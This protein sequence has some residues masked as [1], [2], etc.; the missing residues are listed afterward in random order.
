MTFAPS[1]YDIPAHLKKPEDK[2]E[3]LKE[4]ILIINEK[5]EKEHGA[6]ISDENV[7]VVNEMQ[8]IIEDPK[9]A[10]FRKIAERIELGLKT[11]NTV[12]L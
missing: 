12:H 4:E 5:Q 8:V 10:W 1:V 2:I 7:E 3:G 11:K 6:K 9:E